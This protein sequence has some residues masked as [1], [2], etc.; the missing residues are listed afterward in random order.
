MSIVTLFGRWWTAFDYGILLPGLAR[1]P[2]VQARSLARLRGRFYAL[3]KRDWRTFSFADDQLYQRTF[4]VYKQLMPK[5]TDAQCH[6]RVALRYE[7]QSLEELE[8]ACLPL[9]DISTWPLRVEGLEAVNALL[10]TKPRIVLLTA[11]FGSSIL[12]STMLGCLGM[13]V[14]GM[15]S[16]VVDDPRVHPAIARFYRR[17]YAAITPYMNGGGIIDRQGNA[18]KFVR[19]L[20]RG[21]AVGIVGDLPP[22][23]GEQPLVKMFLGKQRGFAPGAVKLAEM[24]GAKI[25]AYVCVYSGGEYVLRFS[26]PEQDPYQF[27]EEAIR[28]EPSQ[29]WAADLLPLLPEY[30]ND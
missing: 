15:S 17:K 11:H 4:D 2:M 8:G 21:G 3:I 10:A 27:I 22:D 6:A 29:W 9:C 28:S 18:A 14:L 5:A 16:S 24:T 1:L 12:G 7:A 26:A 25:L 20:L 13:P 23:P 30:S 19:F